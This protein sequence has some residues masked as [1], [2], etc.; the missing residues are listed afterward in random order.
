[1]NRRTSSMFLH[2]HV[3][4]FTF[5]TFLKTFDSYYIRTFEFL[6]YRNGVNAKKAYIIL[7]IMLTYEV[8]SEVVAPSVL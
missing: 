6:F 2:F 5:S 3:V 4:V 7:Q 8:A 1:M